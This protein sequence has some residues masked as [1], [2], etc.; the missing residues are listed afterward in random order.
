MN[1]KVL[2]K[3]REL[4]PDEFMVDYLNSM[5]F[6]QPFIHGGTLKGG[7]FS[8]NAG[9]YHIEFNGKKG[10]YRIDNNGEIIEIDENG[11]IIQEESK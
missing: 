9:T 1:N 2:D 3:M 8:L 6:D 11:N 5:D 4:Y 10:L 7:T